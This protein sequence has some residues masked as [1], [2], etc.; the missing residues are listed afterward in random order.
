MEM[1]PDSISP[2]RFVGAFVLVAEPARVTRLAYNGK[3]V[4]VV[5]VVRSSSNSCAKAL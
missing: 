4:D 3:R 5:F 2:S 1:Y